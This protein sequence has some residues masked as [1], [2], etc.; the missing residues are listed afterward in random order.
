VICALALA[1][2]GGNDDEPDPTASAPVT[3]A[4]VETTSRQKG[5]SAGGNGHADVGPPEQLERPLEIDDVLI[6]VL[7]D[8]GSP[9]QA[10]DELVTDAFLRNAYGGRPNCLAAREQGGVARDIEVDEVSESE[11]TA[12]AVAV[13]RGGPYDGVE[14]EVELVA[15]PE[16]EGAWLVEGLFADVPAGP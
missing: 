1:S 2:C 14:V 13:P 3:S 15:D 11:S 7:T 16:L 8:S 9:E 4:P 5:K 10:C 6:A 12:T